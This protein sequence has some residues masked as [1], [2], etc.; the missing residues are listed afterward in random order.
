MGQRTSAKRH[1][2]DIH[3][4]ILLNK[5]TG[6]SS[7]QAM[8][9]LRH[10]IQAKKAGHTGNL[11]PMA[12]GLLPCC[13]GDATKVANLLINADKT[14]IAR[15][16]LGSQTDTGDATGQVIET[17]PVPT[18]TSEEIE[19]ACAALTGDIEQIPPM[20]SALHHQGQ[21]LYDLARQGKTVERPARPVTVHHFTLLAHTSEYLEFEIKVSK[22]TYIRTLLEDFAAQL[23][24]VAHMSALHRTQ[25]GIFTAEHMLDLATIQQRPLSE[26]L[27]PLET[28]LVEYP[29]LDLSE[30]QTQDLI[31]GKK[32]SY[33]IE[34]GI[35]RMFDWT[36]RFLG[37]GEVQH[38]QLKV[39][40][41]FY[42]SYSQ[43]AV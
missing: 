20:Y 10:A 35:Y 16:V 26:V 29:R 18:L 43:K 30:S 14:Y 9:K 15:C 42:K 1:Y 7:N 4:I 17:A 37:L 22:G 2:R 19:Q 12:T 32:I 27:M 40:K 11:D 36:D 23:G 31:H 6:M 28:A 25:T 13:F 5:A 3:G 34:Q 38:H 39:K 24:T 33:T 41:L 21:R 8:Q